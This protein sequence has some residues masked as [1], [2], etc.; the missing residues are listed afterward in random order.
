MLQ[1]EQHANIKFMCK[2][3]KSASEMLSVLQQV[4]SYTALKKFTVYN[5][6]SQFKNRQELLDDDQHSRRPSTFRTKEMIEKVRQLI[7]SD[8]KMTIGELEHE[9]GVSHRS[10][11]AILSND[12]KMRCVSAKIVPRQLT[13]DQMECRMM[14][15][16]D[17][18]ERSTQDLMS[19]KKIVTGVRL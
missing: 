18:F 12:M 15:A 16:G 5:W 13:M 3:G 1:F 4:Y 7:Q 6:F 9:V 19:L 2:L 8:R 17:L 11:H 10:I 14:V